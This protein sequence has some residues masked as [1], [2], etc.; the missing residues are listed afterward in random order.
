MWETRFASLIGQSKIRKPFSHS[1]IWCE[2]LSIYKIK[3]NTDNQTAG[4]N[5]FTA[6]NEINKWTNNYKNF[7]FTHL[8]KLGQW[9][10]PIQQIHLLSQF[11]PDSLLGLRR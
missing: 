4:K 3:A 11:S 5:N 7:I 1:K 10:I 8:P 6:K 2:N 9:E